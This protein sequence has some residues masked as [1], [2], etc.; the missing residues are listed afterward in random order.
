MLTEWSTRRGQICLA[1]IFVL[2]VLMRIPLLA[3]VPNG[4]YHDE[5]TTGYD[6]FSLLETQRD[7]YG[8]FLPL[9]AQSSGA[10]N[11]ALYRYLT[12]PCIA[13]FGLNE[14]SVRLPAA[15]AGLFTVLALYHLTAA[16]SGQRLALLAALL[17]AIS[18][19]HVLC[20][21]F[22]GRVILLPLCFC[23]ALYLFLRSREEPR[24]LP[25]SAAAFALT[26]YTY[27]AARVFVPLFV[28]GLVFLYRRELLETWRRSAVA[29]VLFLCVLVPLAAFW[30]TP[31]GMARAHDTL[32]NDLTAILPQYGSY[33]GPDFLFLAGDSN[34]RHSL[35]GMG[36]LYFF[37]WF[38]V[39]LGIWGLVRDRHR[40]RRILWLWFL[41][42][43]I[44][45]AFTAEKHALRA[46][47][48]APLFAILSAMGIE[49]IL[50]WGKSYRWRLAIG[51]ATTVIVATSAAFFARTYF[52]DYRD[53]AAAAWSHGMREAIAF[54]ENSGRDIVLVSQRFQPLSFVL[55][56]TGF[57][58][59]QYQSFPIGLREGLWQSRYPMG[60]ARYRF[61]YTDLLTLVEGTHLL[62]LRPDELGR[63]DD[64]SYR[65][66]H[67]HEIRDPLGNDVICFVEVAGMSRSQAVAAYEQ[68]LRD[69]PDGTAALVLQQA[70]QGNQ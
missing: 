58:P 46:L 37:E 24:F 39:P 11:E 1:G 4:F 18:P 2:A 51:L 70:L 34:L 50:R 33:F 28:L 17:L 30:I 36:Q 10:Y 44:P 3:S 25:W 15:L 66:R 31:E 64:L 21:R 9:F 22:A 60:F 54:S 7:Q 27:S 35:R 49:Q 56:Y 41:L 53:Y 55:F 69:D 19:W 16:L 14:F 47:I 20:S 26:L 12:V 5:A 67:V 40:D 13:I 68:A 45:A 8:D 32:A 6:A 57:S 48:G 62:M 42:Y 63:L 52:F 65:W 29:A 59:A 61:V 38:T 43:P 23:V